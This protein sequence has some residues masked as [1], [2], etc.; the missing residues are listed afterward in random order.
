[1]ASLIKKLKAMCSKAWSVRPYLRCCEA[2]VVN[3]TRGE[4]SAY[5]SNEG[6]DAITFYI[7]S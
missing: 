2:V 3:I 4:G 5:L 7:N 6:C 1:M